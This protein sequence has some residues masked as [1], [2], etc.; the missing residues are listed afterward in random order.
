MVAGIAFDLY[1]AKFAL[2]LAA[3]IAGV[4]RPVFDMWLNRDHIRRSNKKGRP[5]FSAR[6]IFK[7]K[8]LQHLSISLLITLSK[9]EEV[10]DE[11]ASIAQIVADTGEWMWAVARGV[12]SGNSMVVYAY[13]TRIKSKWKFDM[14]IQKHGEEPSFGWGQ[15]HL[16]VPMS[17]IFATV[18]AECKKS[19]L[20]DTR[21]G[22]S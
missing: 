14:H 20:P 9:Y 5:L 3:K 4:N 22:V 1:E 15:P 11:A 16:Y 8:L 18:Y 17:D 10:A 6:E 12:E 7:A 21:D 13:A 19:L 2:N